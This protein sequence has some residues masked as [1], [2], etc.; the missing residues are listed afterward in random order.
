VLLVGL[1]VVM[2]L[3][4]CGHLQRGLLPVA[5]WLG[6]EGQYR[7][8]VGDRKLVA[9]TIDDGPSAHT[10][11]ILDRLAESG[12]TA[13]FFLHTDHVLDMGAE[14]E[15][16]VRRILAEGHEIGNHTTADVPSISLGAERFAQT[17]TEADRRLRSW[18]VEPTWFRAA[19]GS[20]ESVWMMPMLETHGYRP[21]FA[22]ASFLPWDT[23]LHWPG[24]YGRQLGGAAF[25][26]AILV[27]H[28]GNGPLADRGERTLK[29]LD[30][31]TDRLERRGYRMRSL[32]EVA[33]SA[34]LDAR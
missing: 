5:K 34:E 32:S 6:P 9:L 10:A 27:L 7:F 25:P 31:L 22:M 11:N 30:E 28:E 3:A 18:G 13:T 20:F 4:A 29:T 16:L 21:S 2:S 12:S 19:G 17:F 1:L 33:A 8:D 14:G 26:G 23:F 24:V 15:A